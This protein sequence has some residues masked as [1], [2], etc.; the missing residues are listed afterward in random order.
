MK[1]IGAGTD[2]GFCPQEPGKDPWRRKILFLQQVV[3]L[4]HYT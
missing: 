4:A 1:K 2:S 3:R